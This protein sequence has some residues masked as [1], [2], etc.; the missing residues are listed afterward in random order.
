ILTVKRK[1]RTSDYDLI[2]RNKYGNIEIVKGLDKEINTL[3]GATFEEISDQELVKMNLKN[4]VRIT[5]IGEGPLYR[6]GVK[7]GFILTQIEDQDVNSV[8]DISQIL[9]TAKGGILFEGY[10]PNGTKAY[11]GFGL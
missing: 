8:S 10:Y 5:H 3:L 6:A 7:E 1:N 9:K 2:L 11:Y 4:G